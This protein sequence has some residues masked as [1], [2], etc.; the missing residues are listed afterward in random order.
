MM[1]DSGTLYRAAGLSAVVSLVALLVAAVAIALFFA[2]A[3]Q[4]FGPINDVFVSITMLS[5]ILPILAIDRLAGAEIG[6]WL[7]IVSLAAIAGAV[8]AAA[9]QLLL[10]IGIIDLRSSFITG[11]IGIVP[12]LIWT[13]QR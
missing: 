10:V 13:S 5:L 2:G 1:I 9:G 3:G 7:R 4:V 6:P 11:G 8:L 12:V